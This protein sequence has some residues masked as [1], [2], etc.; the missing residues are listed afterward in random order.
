MNDPPHNSMNPYESPHAVAGG[1]PTN[2]I[3]RPVRG[4]AVWATTVATLLAC[5]IVAGASS[6]VVLG[7]LAT[8][9]PGWK[10]WLP[11][12]EKFAA[13]AAG[14]INLLVVAAAVA[15]GQVRA[16]FFFDSI[17][18]RT[19]A[20]LLLISATVLFLGAFLLEGNLGIAR[21]LFAPAMLALLMGG[22]MYSWCNRL[23]A[24]KMKNRKRLLNLTNRQ[25]AA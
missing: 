8:Q 2:E 9:V 23:F 11:D 12:G 6:Y 22:C 7:W 13:I 20:W 1:A 10:T 15:Y 4:I 18:A 14:A 21:W 19:I 17:W 24:A 3:V 25:D 16:T 5:A